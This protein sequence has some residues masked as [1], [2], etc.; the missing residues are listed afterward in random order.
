M[1]YHF[2]KV[3]CEFISQAS[4]IFIFSFFMKWTIF[5]KNV[6]TFTNRIH[7]NHLKQITR[8][9]RIT[10]V[11]TCGN[12]LNPVVLFK[13]CIKRDKLNN[14][15]ICQNNILHI[16]KV[17]IVDLENTFDKKIKWFTISFKHKS[18]FSDTCNCI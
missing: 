3:W 18:F 10:I 12:A 17:Y 13:M 14:H 5:K 2:Y 11:S 6:N 4:I 16:L 7:T 9:V 15:L 8:C 1:L